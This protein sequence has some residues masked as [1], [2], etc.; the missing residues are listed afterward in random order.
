MNNPARIAEKQR[1][2]IKFLGG[3]Y[4]PVVSD[5][6]IGINFLYDSQPNENGDFL[7]VFS[8]KNDKKVE[9]G[10]PLNQID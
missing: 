8:K 3:R 4:T 5:R 6:V 10:K 1:K 7:N 2:Y 9:V